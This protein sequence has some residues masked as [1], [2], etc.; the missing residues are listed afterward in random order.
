MINR[1]RI[2]VVTALESDARYQQLVTAVEQQ[3]TAVNKEAAAAAGPAVCPLAEVEVTVVHTQPSSA[4]DIGLRSEQN[5]I[6]KWS[7]VLS[8]ILHSAIA[9]HY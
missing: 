9:G 8:T 2:V 1:G 4:G 7:P 3:V 6:K 5:V